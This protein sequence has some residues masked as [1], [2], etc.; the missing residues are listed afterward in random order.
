MPVRRHPVAASKVE[1]SLGR[2]PV[3]LAL[4]GRLKAFYQRLRAEDLRL[5]EIF[6]AKLFAAAPHL[7]SLFRA[8]PAEQAQKLMAALDAVVQNLENPAANAAMLAQLGRR[9]ADYGAQPAHYDLVIDL[10][11]ESMEQLLGPGVDPRGLT[12]WRMALRLISDQMIA[13]STGH[14]A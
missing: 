2:L 3:D 14:V 5:A 4:V 8:A 13:A 9:H 1:V 10:L 11:I 7:R 6:Y 12:E